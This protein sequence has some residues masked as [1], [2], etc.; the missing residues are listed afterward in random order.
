MKANGQL[1][2]ARRRSMQP[3]FTRHLGAHWQ[4]RPSTTSA[5]TH[6]PTPLLDVE[7]R[8]AAYN[9]SLHRC[10][11]RPRWMAALFVDRRAARQALHIHPIDAARCRAA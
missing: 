1:F 3:A 8:L 7:A 6:R 10:A 2:L 9:I 11:Q 5:S 4:A